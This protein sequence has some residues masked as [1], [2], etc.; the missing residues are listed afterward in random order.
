MKTEIEAKFLNIDIDE[1]RNRL[2][3]LGASRVQSERLMKRIIL[4]F[5]DGR[6]DRIGGWVRVRNEGDKT[7]LSYKQQ[8]DDSLHGTKEINIVVSDFNETSELLNAI[9]LSEKS[10]Q[11]TKRE[12]WVLDNTEIEIDT[13]PWVPSFV[14]VESKD[15]ELLN[16]VLKK[17]DLKLENAFHGSVAVVYKQYYDVSEEEVNNMGSITFEEMPVVLI[18]KSKRLCED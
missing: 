9:G 5:P 6:L 3:S 1:F 2:E 17:L 14:E 18:G 11:E 16:V 10:Y 7:T 12:S 15:E 13:W 8:N 4:D